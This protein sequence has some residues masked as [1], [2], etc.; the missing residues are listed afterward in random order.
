MIYKKNIY[1]K[2]IDIWFFSVFISL[3]YYIVFIVDGFKVRDKLDLN[4]IKKDL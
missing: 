4:D 2:I 1:K 3:L